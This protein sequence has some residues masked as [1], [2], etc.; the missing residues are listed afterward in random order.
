MHNRCVSNEVRLWLLGGFRAEVDGQ[1]VAAAAWRRRGATALVKLLAL[2]PGHRLHRE[3]AIDWLWPEAGATAGAARLNKALH[4]AR[5]ALG[6][7]HLRLHDG[8]LSLAA[9]TL[10]VDLDALEAAAGRGD[11]EDALALYTGDLLPEN[12]FDDWAEPRRAQLHEMVAR[13]LL[14]QAADRAG[15]DDPAA[16]VAALE[17][18][19]ALDPLNEEAYARLMRLAAAAGARHVALRWYDRLTEVLHEHLGVE[20]DDGLRALQADI[21]A[22]RLGPGPAPAT[23]PSSPPGPSPRPGAGPAAGPEERKLVTVLDMDLRGLPA[24]PGQRDPERARRETITWTDL[25]CEVAGRWGGAVQRQVGGGVIALFGYPAAR[26]DHA[27]RALWAG[28]EVLQRTPVPVRMGA[29]TGEV[30]APDPAGSD[31][32]SDL[33]L[34]SIGGAV[35]DSAARL[36]E[37][38]RPGTLLAAERTGRA[39]QPPSPSGASRFRFGPPPALGRVGGRG[40]AGGGRAAPGGTRGRAAGCAEPDR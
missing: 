1:P 35:L 6:R 36:R 11:T 26:E 39:A 22:G 25:F 32:G 34:T 16:A 17:R 20:P 18:L 23:G 28:F 5:R 13:L 9:G 27:A 4:F 15:R 29:D 37:A 7:D 33:A 19:V 8:L 10:W 14:D 40:S 21:A 38:A 31:P 30:I 3:Q 2:R 12:R 24:T